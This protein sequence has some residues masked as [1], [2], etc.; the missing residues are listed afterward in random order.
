MNN[1]LNKIFYYFKYFV[2]IIK[3]RE[4]F[5]SFFCNNNINIII[6]TK[7]IITIFKPNSHLI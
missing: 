3:Q 2:N 4:N 6:K 7:N 5:K 1:I